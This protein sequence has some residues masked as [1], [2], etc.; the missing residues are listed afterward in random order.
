[1]LAV[2]EHV[3][4]FGDGDEEISRRATLMIVHAM[5]RLAR[6]GGHRAVD[7]S[8]AVLHGQGIPRVLLLVLADAVGIAS[9]VGHGG[10]AHGP[11]GGTPEIGHDEPQRPSDGPVGAPARAE[12][13][14]RAVDVEGLARGPLTMNSGDGKL[15]VAETPW[16][17][18]A[19]SHIAS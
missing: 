13:P 6:E 10:H 5:G 2:R 17:S 3:E 11:R 12:T 14:C 8:E 9:G 1:R 4:R 18:K 16:R 15:V 19:S 7:G